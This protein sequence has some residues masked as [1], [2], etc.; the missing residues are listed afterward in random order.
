MK[1]QLLFIL[2]F[3]AFTHTNAQ[4]IALKF[5]GGI[6]SESEYRFRGSSRGEWPKV[7]VNNENSISIFK[8]ESAF[9][10]PALAFEQ[11]NGNFG[12]LGFALKSKYNQKQYFSQFD[13]GTSLNIR[14]KINY[15]ITKGSGFDVQ[16]E[17]NIRFRKK[18][19]VLKWVPF[20]GFLFNM[21]ASSM[22][23]T[24]SYVDIFA[25]EESRMGVAAGVVPRIQ[26]NMGKR[27]FLDFSASFF[28]FSFNLEH[29]AYRN[30]AFTEQ[31]QE[32]DTFTSGLFDRYWIRVGTGWKIPLKNK[33]MNIE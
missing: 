33:K 2:S 9:V 31:Q 17:Y 5:Y 22:T 18:E 1:N 26:Y 3:V 30:P 24:P 15:G 27:W 23:F 32:N 8:T 12:E 25:R 20:M 16:L 7:P 4:S 10:M 14:E 29:S 28:V 21:N 13:T 19:E 6:R 11:S